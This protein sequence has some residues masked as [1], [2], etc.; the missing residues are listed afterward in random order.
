M[1]GFVSLGIGLRTHSG[2]WQ[3][4]SRP[5]LGSRRSP[6]SPMR[7]MRTPHSTNERLL[8]TEADA[9]RPSSVICPRRCVASA[10][11]EPKGKESARSAAPQ[12]CQPAQEPHQ[13]TARLLATPRPQPCRC[14]TSTTESQRRYLIEI[15]WLFKNTS[16][17]KNPIISTT[18]SNCR[19]SSASSV[20]S[21]SLGRAARKLHLEPRKRLR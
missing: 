9:I 21:G 16:F 8:N 10:R 17:L 19:Y 3:P 18:S 12:G 14:W 11:S 4:R 15:T 5:K 13:T 1:V 20:G 7:P 2:V 6:L